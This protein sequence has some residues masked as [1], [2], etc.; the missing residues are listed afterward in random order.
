MNSTQLDNPVVEIV[1][2]RR[3][4]ATDMMAKVLLFSRSA[5]MCFTLVI[6]IEV[7]NYDYLAREILL[8]C[9]LTRN[10]WTYLTLHV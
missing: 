10:R 8:F 9:T 3:G 4:T 2:H 5:H 7:G 1:T 6:Q